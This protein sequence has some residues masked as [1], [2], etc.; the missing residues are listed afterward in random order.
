MIMTLLQ[1]NIHNNIYLINSK[2]KFIYLSTNTKMQ[3]KF[4][5]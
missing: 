3:N 5:T 4:Q 1:N 2:N